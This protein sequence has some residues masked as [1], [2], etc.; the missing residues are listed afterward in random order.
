VTTFLVPYWQLSEKLN[1][2][3]IG[4]VLEPNNNSPKINTS[5]GK[6]TEEE[7]MVT[8]FIKFKKANH[9]TSEKPYCVLMRERLDR[10]LL[11]KEDNPKFFTTRENVSDEV[12]DV[13]ISESL[14]W[15]ELE[16]NFGDRVQVECEKN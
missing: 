10:M 1:V 3:F 7:N 13:T 11:N 16:K 12:L 15:H 8:E 5:S 4:K 14:V 2:S 9:L 6:V